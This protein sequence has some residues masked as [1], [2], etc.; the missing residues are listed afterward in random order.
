MRRLQTELFDSLGR[1]NPA[2]DSLEIEL[3]QIGDQGMIDRWEA[4]KTVAEDMTANDE[5]LEDARARVIS[6]QARV[7]AATTRLHKLQPKVTFNDIWRAMRD[8]S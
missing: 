8:A 1:F 4:V 3:R 7:K 2:I 5:A 6:A